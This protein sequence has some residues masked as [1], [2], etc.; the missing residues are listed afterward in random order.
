MQ[1]LQKE[2]PVELETKPAKARTS[3]TYVENEEA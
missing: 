1:A 2:V 3:E